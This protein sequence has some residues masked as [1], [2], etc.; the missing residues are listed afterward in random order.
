MMKPNPIILLILLPAFI[1][2]GCSTQLIQ[3]GTETPSDSINILQTKVYTN[4]EPSLPMTTPTTYTPT[5]TETPF[6]TMEPTQARET[7]E[8]FLKEPMNCAEPC[9]WGI[10]PGKT[11]FEVAKK[12]FYSLGFVPFAGLDTETGKYFFTISYDVDSGRDST[13]TLSSSGD[14]VENIVITPEIDITKKGEGRD[15]VAYSPETI[16]MKYGNPSRVVFTASATQNICMNMIMYYDQFDLIAQ[17]HG[18]DMD[19]WNFCP[20]IDKFD[21]VRLSIG[22][23]P[24]TKPSF[25]TVPLEKAS[26]LTID[27][28]SK[29]LSGNP[30]DACIQFNNKVFDYGE[31]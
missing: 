27:E 1:L 7:I 6:V 25:E 12:F 24:I 15:W 19:S 14:L 9:I 30:Q 20:L 17:Y 29:L 18:C 16:I 21:F 23:D 3:R 8:L 13:I 2:I 4:T 10:R 22:P 11:T 5:K 28:F 31:P 26:S